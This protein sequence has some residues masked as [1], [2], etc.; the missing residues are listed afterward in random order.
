MAGD[1]NQPVRGQV[2][3][4]PLPF[5]TIVCWQMYWYPQDVDFLT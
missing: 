4:L 2:P 3:L 5:I 1:S